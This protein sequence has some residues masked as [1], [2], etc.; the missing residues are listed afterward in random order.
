MY[1]AAEAGAREAEE[2]VALAPPLPFES[3]YEALKI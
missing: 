1:I 2:G 3:F